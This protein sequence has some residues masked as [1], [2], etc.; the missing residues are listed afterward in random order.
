MKKIIACV[1][2]LLLTT[3]SGH[4]QTSNNQGQRQPQKLTKAEREVLTRNQAWCDAIVKGEMETLDQLLADDYIITSSTST[5]RD[6]QAEMADVKLPAGLSWVFIKTDDL[7]VRVYGQTAVVTGHIRWRVRNK[8][9]EVDDERR[10]TSVFVKQ[11]GQWRIVAQQMTRP[12]QQNQN[13]N[14]NQ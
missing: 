1:G 10:F 12:P 7:R 9:R 2:M 11:K 5:L 3:F 13:Q 6:K 14:Q 4:G 8:D